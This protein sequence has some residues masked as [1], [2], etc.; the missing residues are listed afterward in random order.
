MSDKR[1]TTLKDIAKA[2]NLSP[3]TVSRALNGYPSL[4]EETIQLVKDY[5]EKHN[6]VPNPIAVNFR[7]NRTSIIGMI[8][9][10]IV[11]HFFST[12]ISGA[13]ETAKKQGYSI[14]LAQSQDLLK[15]EI[16]ASQHLLGMGVDGLLI[17]VSNE[18][19]EAD[20]LQAF[21]DEGKP[22]VQFDKVTDQLDGP[23][24]EV[25]DFE[26]A[27]Q[28]VS[29]LIR[30]GYRKIAHLSGRMEVKNAHERFLGYKKALKD[31]GLEFNEK[32]VKNCF[33][34]SEQEGFEFTHELM[35]SADR[36]DAIFCITDLVALGSM[37]YLKSSGYQIPKQIGLM[38]FSNWML[39]EYTSPS[40]SSVDQF[41][42]QMGSKAA[43][44]LIDLLKKQE[45]GANERLEVKT[46]VIIRGSSMRS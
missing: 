41:G 19:K 22:V 2:L 21:L 37:N 44:L 1:R 3:S 38:G 36:P 34:I 35:A 42:T 13:M 29:H 15:D 46:E 12:T 33:D 7:K 45:L 39:S 10:H 17:S 26:G 20:H 23:K 30:Q 18:T 9:P 40:L 28:A 43:A 31:H 27:Y 5:A 32:W 6:Y 16:L 4:S 8:V 25:D 24:I 11:H 14:L